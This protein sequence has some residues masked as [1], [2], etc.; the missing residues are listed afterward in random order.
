MRLSVG[1]TGQCWDNAVAESFFTTIK[2]ELLDRQAWPTKAKA[3]KAIFECIEGLVQ[4]P[5]TAFQ[6]RLPQ[7]RGLGRSSR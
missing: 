4:H 6:P 1:R 5:P 2:T 7:P 3:H